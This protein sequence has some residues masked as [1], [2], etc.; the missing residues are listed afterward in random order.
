MRV[1]VAGLGVLARVHEVVCGKCQQGTHQS[2]SAA[3]SPATLEV[4]ID[5]TQIKPKPCTATLS[6]TDTGEVEKDASLRELIGEGHIAY[7][8]HPLLQDPACP[9]AEPRHCSGL[10]LTQA[11]LLAAEES[12]TRWHTL[13]KDEVWVDGGQGPA[14]PVQSGSPGSSN[15]AGSQDDQEAAISSSSNSD[16]DEAASSEVCRPS[17]KC[18]L[19]F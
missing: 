5:W 16:S 3:D 15:A 10:Q 6:Y 13:A 7:S 11:C 1:F 2:T 12:R 4:N 14:G 8:E 19:A 9:P 17:H 18:A